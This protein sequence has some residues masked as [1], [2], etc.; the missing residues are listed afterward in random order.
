MSLDVYDNLFDRINE[1]KERN[2]LLSLIAESEK[3]LIC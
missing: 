2:I 3:V 1:V